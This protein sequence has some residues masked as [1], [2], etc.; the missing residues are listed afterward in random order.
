MAIDPAIEKAVHTR[1]GC[2]EPT[3]ISALQ[4]LVSFRNASPDIFKP[5]AIRAAGQPAG[6][7]GLSACPAAL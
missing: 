7:V 4:W 3:H 2:G 1:S 5:S 6:P